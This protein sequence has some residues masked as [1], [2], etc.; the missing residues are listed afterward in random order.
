MRT[1]S[2][3]SESFQLQLLFFAFASFNSAESRLNAL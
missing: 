2:P 1:V 3:K